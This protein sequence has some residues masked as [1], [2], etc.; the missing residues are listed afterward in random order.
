MYK[1]YLV[2]FGLV[3]GLYTSVFKVSRIEY[4]NYLGPVVQSIIGLISSLRGQL[5]KCFVTFITDYSD[6]SC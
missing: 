3:N 1:P 2:F 6:L 4:Q 5:F